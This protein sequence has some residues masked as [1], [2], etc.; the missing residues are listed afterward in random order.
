MFLAQEAQNRIPSVGIAAVSNLFFVATV[1]GLP[2]EYFFHL[3]P[4]PKDRAGKG[5][6]EAL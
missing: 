2:Q 1:T 4:T 3:H 5:W 6:G